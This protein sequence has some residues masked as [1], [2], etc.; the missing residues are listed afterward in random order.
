MSKTAG[1]SR[2]TLSGAKRSLRLNRGTLAFVLTSRAGALH[3]SD[4]RPTGRGGIPSR[5]HRQALKETMHVAVADRPLQMRQRLDGTDAASTRWRARRVLT[6][7]VRLWAGFYGGGG[8]RP[9]VPP[10]LAFFGTPGGG[11]PPRGYGRGLPRRR[12]GGGFRLPFVL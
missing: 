7:E 8:G 5:L 1:K 9:E 2:R 12:Q 4:E 6:I 3:R 10:Q 11:E